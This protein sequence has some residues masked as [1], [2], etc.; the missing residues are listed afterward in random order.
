MKEA[1]LVYL[2]ASPIIAAFKLMA[3]AFLHINRP[4]GQLYG[5]LTKP[6]K[7]WRMV[8]YTAVFDWLLPVCY[9]V[10]SEIIYHAN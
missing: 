4:R 6:T 5:P 1:F 9:L 2:I 7:Y 10:I 8:Y 3:A